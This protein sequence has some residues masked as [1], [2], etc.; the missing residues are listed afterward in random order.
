MK[1]GERLRHKVLAFL[2][3]EIDKHVTPGAVIRIKHKG[4]VILEEAIGTNSLKDDCVTMTSR[5]I[6]DMASLTK[7]MVTLPVMLQLLESGDIHLNDKVA[8]FLPGFAK[9]GKESITLRQLLTHSSGLIAHRPYFERKL[10]TPEVLADI[11]EEQ[12]SYESDQKVVYSDL[13]YI[14]LMAVMEKV[15]GQPLEDYSKQHLFHPL[16]MMDTGYLPKYER[17]QY[18]PTEFLEHLKDHKYGIVHDDNT[19]FMGGIS[20]HAGL[21]ST[22]KDVS[23]FTDMLENDG[24]CEGKQIV[25]PEWLRKSRENFTPFSDESR[26]LGWQ[27]KGQGISPA[28]DLMS[29]TTY[30]HTGYTGTSFYI[31][32]SRE[33]TVTLLT[34]RVYFGRQDPIIRL[35]P[36]LHN[37]IVTNLA[38]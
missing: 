20:G 29:P 15:T 8:K 10:T 22:M 21:F 9:N 14:F 3:Q 30:G 13:G 17:I 11:L 2:Q 4:K 12:L 36:R 16:G 25:H 18:A 27:L 6:F 24:M 33:L 1:R 31:D 26:G 32:P 19:E 7:V 38:N 37:I 35:R 34:N 5:H 23:N 28:G